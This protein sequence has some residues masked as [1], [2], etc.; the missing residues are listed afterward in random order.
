MVLQSSVSRSVEQTFENYNCL[1]T[2]LKATVE[3]HSSQREAVLKNDVS[4]TNMRFYMRKEK[5]LIQL[6][7]MN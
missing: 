2:T 4:G 1:K 7:Q 3:N 6:V 5:G